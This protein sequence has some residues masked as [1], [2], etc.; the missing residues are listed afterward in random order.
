MTPNIS[1]PKLPTSK[2]SSNAAWSTTI[3][4]SCCRD[5][6]VA[7]VFKLR[8]SSI[9]AINSSLVTSSS[10]WGYT[11]CSYVKRSNWKH[12]KALYPLN[13]CFIL[14]LQGW[15]RIKKKSNLCSDT[16]DFISPSRLHAI[17]Q[18]CHWTEMKNL[19]LTNKKSG[20]GGKK[21]GIMVQL[22]TKRNNSS[23]VTTIC[24]SFLIS[25]KE[26]FELSQQFVCVL[27]MSFLSVRSDQPRAS[28]AFWLQSENIPRKISES[29]SAILQEEEAWWTQIRL[30]SHLSRSIFYVCYCRSS[31]KTFKNSSTGLKRTKIRLNVVEKSR[32]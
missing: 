27:S 10:N 28:W 24:S 5:W 21:I 26:C 4:T 11:T 7:I 25:R 14:H 29:T 3:S 17:M 20:S 12:W 23:K 18:T 31:P 30:R 1:S 32:D 2:G 8:R 15:G 16:A 9:T 19:D 6:T 13:D 22:A